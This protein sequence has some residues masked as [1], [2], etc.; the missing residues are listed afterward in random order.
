MNWA[1]LMRLALSAS[2]LKAD[3]WELQEGYV[4]KVRK[5]ALF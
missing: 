2:A 4:K 1:R 3:A 5:Y